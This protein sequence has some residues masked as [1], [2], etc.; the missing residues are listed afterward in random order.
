MSWK[1]FWGQIEEGL[2]ARLGTS[3]KTK[4]RFSIFHAGVWDLLALWL[5]SM[6]EK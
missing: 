1:H 2:P 3:S 6:K 4:S 5:L